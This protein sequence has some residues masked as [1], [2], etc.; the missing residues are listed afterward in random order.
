MSQHIFRS[1]DESIREGLTWDE[2]WQGYDKGLIK[3]W[4][5]GREMQKKRPELAEQALNGELPPMGWKGGIDKKTKKGEKIGTL[6][7]LAQ[8]YGI[9]GDDLDVDLSE[10]PELIC[11]KTGMKVIFTGDYKKYA[12]A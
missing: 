3:C 1:K 2:S 5:V 12:N 9:R 11:T 8:W 10:E 6:N 7:Y 4:E